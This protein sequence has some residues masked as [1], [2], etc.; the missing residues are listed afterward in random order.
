MAQTTLGRTAGT[1]GAYVGGGAT[2][3]ARCILEY[4]CVTDSQGYVTYGA[5]SYTG[6]GGREPDAPAWFGGVFRLGDT[7]GMDA[8]SITD[9]GARFESGSISD[10][11][12]IIVIP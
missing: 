11:E 12:S 4:A 9:L 3:P 8:G 5:Q 6:E 2:D 10:A 7:T 1:Y